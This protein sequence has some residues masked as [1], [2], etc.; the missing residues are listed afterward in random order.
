MESSNSVSVLEDQLAVDPRLLLGALDASE[1]H[2]LITD[3]KGQIVFANLS[4]A[5]RHGRIREEL[6]GESVEHIVR[7]DNH[8]P[9]QRQK[10][11][12]AMRESRPIRVIV[13]GVHS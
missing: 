9:S 1:H 2:V 11:R 7:T 10:M 6:I 13:Q 4:L 5:E 8:S 3:R 12:D